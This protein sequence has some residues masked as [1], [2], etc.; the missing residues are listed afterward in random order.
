VQGNGT[1]G[2]AKGEYGIKVD[3]NYFSP[4]SNFQALQRAANDHSAKAVFDIEH[5]GFQIQGRVGI[6]NE[7]KVELRNL[8]E[9]A[10]F[11]VTLGQGLL[12]FTTYQLWGQPQKDVVYSNNSR[13]EVFMFG[14]LSQKML[15]A[16]FFHELEHVVLGDFG[17][18]PHAG[19]HDDPGVNAATSRAEAEAY[20]NASTP[21]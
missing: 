21:F 15:A 10:G 16:S 3:G 14:D 2:F 5:G 6:E 13:T 20:K 19:R 1:N 17:R 9:V 11:P 4:S 18:T 12:G 7:G 8:T